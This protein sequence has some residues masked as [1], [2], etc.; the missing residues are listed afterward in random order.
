MEQPSGEWFDPFDFDLS[1][2][3]IIELLAQE[4]HCPLCGSLYD[5]SEAKLVR[6]RDGM[7]TLAVQC[8]CC[9]TGSLIT[10]EHELQTATTELT[11][12]ERAFFAVLRPICDADVQRMRTLLEMHHGDLRDLL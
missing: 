10:V 7:I 3:D 1:Q 6:E 2:D 5:Q 9:G 4:R 11:P 12:V 8:H